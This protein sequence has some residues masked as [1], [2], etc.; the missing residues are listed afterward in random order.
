MTVL[1]IQNLQ[2]QMALTRGKTPILRG[3]DLSIEA[4]ETCGLVGESG[5]GKTMVAKALLGILPKR[6]REVRGKLL[7]RGQDLLTLSPRHHRRL[8]GRDITLIPQD[9]MVALNPVQTI[10]RQF[11]T[12]LKRHTDWSRVQL[13]QLAID[14]LLQVSLSEPKQLLKRYPHELSGG[15]R[16]RVLIA[17]AFASKPALVIADEPTT[18][19]DVTV[20]KR[21]LALL[22]RL[23]SESDTAV[24]FVTHDLGVVAKLCDSVYVMHSGRV[25][26]HGRCEQIIGNPQHRYT[27]A[28]LNATPHFERPAAS[29]KPVDVSVTDQLQCELE[30]QGSIVDSGALHGSKH[31]S[32]RGSKHGSKG[33]L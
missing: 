6:V 11:H 15:M 20:Q 13:D 31:G 22:K 24:L 30:L 26:E 21:V 1:D 4:G 25:V 7:F 18:A 27:Q 19:L 3:V 12:A 29:L 33:E 28:L 8:L 16:Q 17:M 2:L 5:A 9:P 14:G 32:K 10:G 23:Q